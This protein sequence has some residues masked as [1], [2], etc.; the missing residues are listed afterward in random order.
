MSSEIKRYFIP[1]QNETF[2]IAKDVQKLEDKVKKLEKLQS[3]RRCKTCNFQS[4][5]DH[6]FT[7][8]FCINCY[9]GE[10]AKLEKELAE[11]KESTEAVNRV[12]SLW[13]SHY[14]G[15]TEALTFIE[16]ELTSKTKQEAT[17]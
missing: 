3:E 11:I 13:Y 1:S 7:G 15:S 17:K 14:M 5:H 4:E 12:V 2:C 6:H 16:Q 9:F 8:D 10:I